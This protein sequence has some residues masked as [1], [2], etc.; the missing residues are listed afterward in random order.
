MR[1]VT[2]L[3]FTVV[4]AVQLIL[5]TASTGVGDPEEKQSPSLKIVNVST[6]R[7]SFRPAKGETVDIIYRLTEPAV[8]D[9]NI[10][11]CRNLLIR[12]LVKGKKRGGG[13]RRELWDGRDEAGRP[14][15][16][17]VYTYTI[18]A[19]SEKG[20]IVNYDITDLTGGEQQWGEDIK[21]DPEKKEIGYV[22]PQAGRVNVRLGIQEGPL[23][24]T[25][26]DWPVRESGL[27]FEPWDGTCG[28]GVLDFGGN[29]KLDIAIWSYTLNGNSIVVLGN[30]R[31]KRPRFIEDMPW[32][33]TYR[34]ERRAKPR[35]LFNHWRHPREACRDPKI[36]L[37]AIDVEHREDGI[38]IIGG[39]TYFQ[40]TIDRHD[41]KIMI[42]QKFEVVFYVDGIFVYEEEL[43]YTPF[44]WQWD[45]VGVNAGIH[46]ITVV[47]RG[48]Q[49][50]FGSTTKKVWVRRIME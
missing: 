50:H 18:K 8:V 36:H 40:M 42:D 6:D 20:S 48:Y 31:E 11:D 3:F 25:L 17:E 12:Q 45:P 34:E 21:Y 5:V 44:A 15:P 19:K 23:L 2:R 29:P 33:K 43:G 7:L 38:P 4:A 14:V 32:G 41:K 9:V 39:E 27:N 35:Q 46:H 16:P 24:S 10:Y 1:Y 49:G 22:L 30:Q 37:K 13:D 26:I 47:L 28:S